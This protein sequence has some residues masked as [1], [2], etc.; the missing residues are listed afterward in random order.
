MAKQNLLTRSKKNKAAEYLRANRLQDA[1]ALYASICQVDRIDVEAWVI[2]GII[3]RKLGRF[4]DAETFCRR[5][6]EISPNLAT[7]YHALGAAVQ[8]QGRLGEAIANY[9]RAIQLH[10]DFADAHY[11]LANALREAGSLIEAAASYRQAVS[12]Q[13]D[14]VEALC[15]LGAVLTSLGEIPEAVSVLN[16]AITLRPNAPQILC[17]LGDI[18]QGE[19]RLGEALDKYQLALR[20]APDFLDAI[21]HT[22]ALLEKINRL[23]EAAELIQQ[24]LPRLPDNP[25]L[26]AVAAKL[27]RRANKI[28]EA[29]ALLERAAKQNLGPMAAGEVHLHLGQMYDRKGEAERAFAHLSEGN[30]L[31]AQATTNLRSNHQNQ[32][33][34]RVERMRGYLT[35]D[36]ASL[37]ERPVLEDCTESPIFLLGFPRSGTTLLEQILD[38]H[39]ALQTLEEKATVSAMV[40][41][42]EEMAQGRENAL[43]ELSDD[44]IKQLR[45]VYFDEAARHVESKPNCL[46][47]DKMPL[48]TINV[49]LIWRVFPNAKFILAIRHPCDVCF[50]SFMQNFLINEAMAGFFTLESGAEIYRDVMRI[51]LEA[52][53]LLPLDYHRIRY[54]DLVADFEKETRALL[55]FLG[56]GWD[57]S[58]LS[59]T[60]HA[61]KRGTINTPS[62]HQ[63]TQPIYQHA[64]YRWKRYAKQFE[65]VMPTLKPFIDYFG[66][67]EGDAA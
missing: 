21:G 44:Q 26:L 43:A 27:A 31:V 45:K 49:H 8:C 61:I 60:D 6:V 38:S 55:D 9:R 2:R 59:H 12:L 25:E 50:S 14:F 35:P 64:K 11:F 66:Y 23:D 46:L 7:A 18:L 47:V 37:T 54:E 24:H 1:E 62:Y 20:L 33:L 22:A 3:N 16:K 36:L 32:Y 40:Q 58:V 41:A 39:P 15:N 51:W 67:A 17:N 13:P 29:I 63:V 56:V 57:D 52:V 4:Q 19:G 5:A 34:E 53:R 42:F 65:P 28:D 48:N 10:P 30:R